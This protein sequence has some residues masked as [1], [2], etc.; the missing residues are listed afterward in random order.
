MIRLKQLLLT[1]LV[2]FS[3]LACSKEDVVANKCE[4]LKSVLR[5]TDIG[6]IKNAV[7]GYVAELPS[8]EYT[9]Q[10][11]NNL[12]ANISGKCVVSATLICFDCIPT[13]PSA[14]EIKLSFTE[15]G[16]TVYKI[17]D[18]TTF[19]GSNKIKVQSAHE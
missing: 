15:N 4:N 13:L 10:N 3:F 7:Q 11:I 16:T 5:G 18:L 17:I 9:E 19:A 2:S 12:I 6:S 1:L 14:S 8:Q